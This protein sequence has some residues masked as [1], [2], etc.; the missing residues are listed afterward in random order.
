MPI[1]AIRKRAQATTIGA[2]SVTLTLATTDVW[3]PDTAVGTTIVVNTNAAAPTPFWA[4]NARYDII[5][6]RVD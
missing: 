4:A 5:V 6:Q 3:D 2:T 1:P